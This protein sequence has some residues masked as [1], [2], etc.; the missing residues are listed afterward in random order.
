V[1]TTFTA[2][3]GRNIY[4]VTVD[5]SRVTPIT[6]GGLTSFPD[7]GTHPLAPYAA[8]EFVDPR[9]GEPSTRGLAR[10]RCSPGPRDRAKDPFLW[11]DPSRNERKL[12]EN[13]AA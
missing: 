10:R 11:P 4:T 7:S 8:S 9:A 13:A 3:A 2:A 5:R 12:A 6:C 1:F